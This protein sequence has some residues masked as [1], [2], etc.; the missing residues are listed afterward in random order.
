MNFNRHLELRDRHAILSPSKYYW[1][2]YDDDRLL[3]FFRSQMAVARGTELHDF[4]CRCIR[5]K[6]SLPKSTATLNRYVND[7][8]G[9]MMIPEQPLFYSDNCFGTADAI[10]YD[11]KEKRLRIHDLKTG[12]VPASIQQLYIY[13]ALFCLEYKVQPDSIRTELRIYQNDD[14]IKEKADPVQIGDIMNRIVRFDLLLEKA[15]AQVAE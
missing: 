15:K 9:F 5:L 8:L 6:I 1:S 3:A 12:T 11:E 4:A 14:I 7:A 2:N 10:A 13:A